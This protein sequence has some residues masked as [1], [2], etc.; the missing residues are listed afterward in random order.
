MTSFVD[1]LTRRYKVL[2]VLV[3]PDR[4]LDNVAEATAATQALNA[5][6]ERLLRKNP[7]KKGPSASASRPGPPPP[8]T[9]AEQQRD[10]VAAAKAVDDDVAV[11]STGARTR[12]VVSWTITYRKQNGS[13]YAPITN[14]RRYTLA[15]MCVD[16]FI[17]FYPLLDAAGYCNLYSFGI[18]LPARSTFSKGQGSIH[19]QGMCT[20]LTLGTDVD[21]GDMIRAF[22]LA[23]VPFW[24]PAFRGVEVR[25][26]VSIDPTQDVGYLFLYTQKDYVMEHA[27][28]VD[29][30]YGGSDYDT[31]KHE[32]WTRN[33]QEATSDTRGHGFAKARRQQCRAVGAYASEGYVV[34]AVAPSG[35]YESMTYAPSQVTSGRTTRKRST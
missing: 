8:P 31:A 15:K 4:N 27:Y 21:A 16:R 13:H 11:P 26:Y 9:S 12:F 23:C 1:R 22:L 34:S 25:P 5:A 24:D 30:S 28:R 2:I 17:Q 29:E 19:I 6:H 33:Y 35:I 14:Q 32:N 18:E 10:P 7:P 3:H 20:A